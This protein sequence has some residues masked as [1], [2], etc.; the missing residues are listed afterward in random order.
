V[1][2]ILLALLA[3]GCAEPSGELLE[4][5]PEPA[6]RLV[7]GNGALYVGS[8]GGGVFRIDLDGGPTET[9]LASSEV[10]QEPFGYFSS[11]DVD[12]GGIWYTIPSSTD[13]GVARTLPDGGRQ[14][15]ATGLISPHELVRSAPDTFWVED[16][17]FGVAAPAVLR[18]L[19]DGANSP[20]NLPTPLGGYSSLAADDRY[21]YWIGNPVPADGISGILWAM[22]RDGGAAIQLAT[23]S[24]HSEIRAADGGVLLADEG[25][26]TYSILRAARPGEPF[27]QVT[28]IVRTAY[29]IAFDERGAAGAYDTFEF[30]DA[31]CDDCARPVTAA[32]STIRSRVGSGETVTLAGGDGYFIYLAMDASFVYWTATLTG[33]GGASI[34]RAR[35]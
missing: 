22:P 6:D 15:L 24:V 18:R 17:P 26:G 1:R 34:Y 11:F 19:R 25:I 16:P 5:L 10:G 29:G 23:P 31:P 9:V 32:H 20:E 30:G 33:R 8:Y 3:V 27:S 7:L 12:D 4:K 13:G 2:S 35:R 28:T 14:L 21:L